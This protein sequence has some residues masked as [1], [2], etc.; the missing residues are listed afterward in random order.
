MPCFCSSLLCSAKRFWISN[1]EHCR[2]FQ[3]A[4]WNLFRNTHNKKW[5]SMANLLVIGIQK[6]YEWN[7][8]ATGSERKK[9]KCILQKNKWD[10]MDEAGLDALFLK[11][12][13]IKSDCLPKASVESAIS[14]GYYLWDRFQR[15]FLDPKK[16]PTVFIGSF[17]CLWTTVVGSVRSYSMQGNIFNC[18]SSCWVSVVM[19][20]LFF[21][22]FLLMSGDP[23]FL[24]VT[25]TTR[26]I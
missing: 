15:K 21:V 4:D 11:C 25:H 9:I 14:L 26:I 1:N 7:Q 20:V 18:M 24:F 2:G 5:W 19:R 10:W 12:N 6:K 22:A 17:L 3:S 16:M 8:K 13:P 23:T